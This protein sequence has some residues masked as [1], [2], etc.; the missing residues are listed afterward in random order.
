M[1]YFYFSILITLNH[2]LYAEDQC[3]GGQW[4]PQTAYS[5]GC[6]EYRCFKR[7][8]YNSDGELC[9][10]ILDF[11]TAE[12]GY[13][14]AM[15]YDPSDNLHAMERYFIN[16][17]SKGMLRVDVMNANGTLLYYLDQNNNALLPSG[18]PL[19]EDN[20]NPAGLFYEFVINSENTFIEHAQ[21][22]APV[23]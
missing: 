6:D 13:F 3:A 2:G 9:A 5:E 14:T 10:R 19:P 4:S 17:N 22:T 8:L 1:K 21:K 23:N 12:K 7:E 18:K 16:P 20:P 15:I 11:V